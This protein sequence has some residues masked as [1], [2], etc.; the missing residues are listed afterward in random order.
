LPLSRSCPKVRGVIVV[1]GRGPDSNA[2][3]SYAS[4]RGWDDVHATQ[5]FQEVMRTV[6]ADRVDAVL[7]AGL[8]GLGKSLPEFART[9]R[10]LAERG[11]SLLI[12]SLGIVDAAS[13][14]VLLNMIDAVEESANVMVRESTKR[15]LVR[16]RRHGVVLGRPSIM[17]AYRKDIRAMS[18]V[19]LSGRKIASELGVPASSVFNELR[20]IKPQ[21]SRK[22]NA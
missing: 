10:E 1:Y 11:V 3:A 5:D 13:R 21:E 6:R 14:Q 2:L 19:G 17:R 18:A 12:P 16:A 4:R 20:R 8:K 15:G 22:L 9:V 7:C